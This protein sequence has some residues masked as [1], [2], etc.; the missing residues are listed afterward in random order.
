MRNIQNNKS[1]VKGRFSGSRR[2]KTL[3]TPLLEH[4]SQG[5]KSVSY[6][7]IQG[8]PISEKLIKCVKLV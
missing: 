3:K 6:L 5:K 1:Q 2:G 4:I 7:S 8:Q